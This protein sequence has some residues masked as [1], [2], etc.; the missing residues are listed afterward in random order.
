MLRI[1]TVLCCFAMAFAQHPYS[2]PGIG[3]RPGAFSA[4]SLG[5]GHT[6][7][8][9]QPGPA[10][11]LGN[12]ATLAFQESRWL[13]ALQSDVSRVKETR[14]YP[15]YDSFDGILNYNNYAI[16]DHLY[17]KLDGGV[18][19]KVKTDKVES[20]VLSL[21]SYS[22]YSFDYTYHEEVRN[23]FSSGGIQDRRLG[24]NRIENEGDLRSISIGAASKMNG[25][26]AVGA[27]VSL[28]SGDWTM[29][30]G[31]YYADPDSIN[32]VE[33]YEF[34]PSGTPAEFNLGATYKINERVSVGARALMPT[35]DFSYDQ[36]YT[37]MEADTTVFTSEF[38]QTY[39][40]HFA[41]GVQYRPQNEF[42]PLLMLE[43][44]LHTYSDVQDYLDDSF[45]IRAGVE[46]QVVPGTPVRFGF[47]YMSSPEDKERANTLFTAGIGFGL[48]RLTGDFGVEIGRI[49]YSDADLFPQSLYG[50]A[51]RTDSDKVETALFRG[52][53]SLSWAL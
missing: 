37:H 12:P 50:D 42:R 19:Y 9:S 11:L 40:K 48:D 31:V 10:A 51:D 38:D 29:L 39:P 49:N 20:L 13:L 27:S 36:E 7:L 47:V 52:M 16:N 14:S 35:G 28:L 8:T 25:P 23:R 6:H 46:Q 32:K 43:G 15:F 21:A 3:T 34:S 44:E 5:L 22:T 41:V 17:S 53:I 1:L 33:R 45:E 26:L 30:R 4:R 24:E 2:D 18:A